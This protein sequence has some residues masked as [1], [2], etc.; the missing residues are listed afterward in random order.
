MGLADRFNDNIFDV[1]S[2]ENVKQALSETEQNLFVLENSNGDKKSKF[3]LLKN[4]LF[5]KVVN[6]PCWFDFDEKT[7]LDL[8]VKFLVAKNIKTPEI[9]AK[10]LKHSFLGF[11]VFDEYLIQNEISAIYYC[12]GE[13]LIYTKNFENVTDNLILPLNKIHMIVKN[14][15]NMAQSENK[16]GVYNFRVN[17][18]WVELR[19]VPQTKIKLSIIKI[20]DVFLEK[21]FKSVNLSSLVSVLQA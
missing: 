7:Q 10:V 17:N 14:V 11:G 1:I 9:F 2:S 8:I 6:V 5:E 4:E 18:F 15:K 19:A 13:P 3:D 16:N 21:Q 20:N 12:E